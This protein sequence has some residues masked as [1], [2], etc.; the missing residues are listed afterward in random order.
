MFLRRRCNVRARRRGAIVVLVAILLAALLGVAA[1]SI[2]AARY[3]FLYC[4]K[5]S[6]ACALGDFFHHGARL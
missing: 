2:D 4:G 3:I 6:G 1:L 5:Q